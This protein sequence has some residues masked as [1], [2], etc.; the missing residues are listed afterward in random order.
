MVCDI[1]DLRCIFVNELV[2]TTILTVILFSVLYFVAAIK[3]KWGFEMTIFL[4]APIVLLFTLATGGF[5]QVFI[6]MGVIAGLMIA[7]TFN[8]IIGNR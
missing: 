5:T 3:L 8:K 4:A 6:T 7:I 2:G 1:L